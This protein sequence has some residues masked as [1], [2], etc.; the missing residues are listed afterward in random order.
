[1][2]ALSV[3]SKITIFKTLAISKIV[4]L[5]LITSVPAFVIVEP[6][7]MKRNI[8]QG[9]KKQNIALYEITTN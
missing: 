7:I 8:C 2:R 3:E 1:M 4:H 6:N 5:G 9:K